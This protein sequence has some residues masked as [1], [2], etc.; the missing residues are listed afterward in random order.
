MVWHEI[1]SRRAGNHIA[2]A[3]YKLMKHIVACDDDMNKF[4]LWSDSCVPENKNSFMTI[5]LQTFLK[6]HPSV[7]GIV[8]RFSEPGHGVVQEV[9]AIHSK[10]ERWLKPMEIFS[11]LSLV[12]LL[13]NKSNKSNTKMNVI[14]M[15]PCDF[16]I[17]K[18]LQKL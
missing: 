5:A 2:S 7:T 16:L 4:I 9:D 3:V 6:D 15:M 8:Q 10:I 14:Q 1:I 12:R 17:S 13:V 18:Q 11:P